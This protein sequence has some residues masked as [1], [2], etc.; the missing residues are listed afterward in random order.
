MVLS[1]SLTTNSRRPFFASAIEP[2]EST[3]GKPNGGCAA[4]PV[5]PVG[6]VGPCVSVPS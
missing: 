3:I 6:T 1:P 2:D 4:I 5:P